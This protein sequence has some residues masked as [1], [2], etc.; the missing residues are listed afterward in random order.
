MFATILSACYQASP[1]DSH[2]HAVKRIFRYLK[3]TPNLRLWYPHDSEFKVVGYNDSDH[4]VFVAL[5]VKSLQEE[6]NC[7][8]IDW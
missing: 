3:H 4:G 1:K 7:L 8:E 5:I 2:L 6:L